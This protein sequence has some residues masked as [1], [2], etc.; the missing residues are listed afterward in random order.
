MGAN[1]KVEAVPAPEVTAAIE[2][3]GR[4]TAGLRERI[5]EKRETGGGGLIQAVRELLVRH[6]DNCDACQRVR[7]LLPSA[8]G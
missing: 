8:S 1:G 3:H 4:V 6:N 5:R 2:E 7:R